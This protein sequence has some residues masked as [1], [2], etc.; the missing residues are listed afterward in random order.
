MGEIS[1]EK[2]NAAT[3][4]NYLEDDVDM[5][6]WHD[7]PSSPFEPHV[8]DQENVAP[9][10][11][12]TPSKPIAG[13]EDEPQSA[14]RIAP[15]KK[16]GLQDRTSP[17]KM[18]PK[19]Q[20]LSAFDEDSFGSSTSRTSPKKASP[21]KQTPTKTSR[22][23]SPDSFRQTSAL[24]PEDE[25]DTEPTPLSK[26]SSSPHQENILRENE[27]LTVAMRLMDQTQAD[28]RE[29]ASAQQTRSVEINIGDATFD[30]TEFNPDGPEFTS[31]DDTSF[32]M[33][34][35]MPGIDM[36]KFAALRQSPT[37][38]GLID[39]VSARSAHA[40]GASKLT[41]DHRQRPALALR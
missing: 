33:F 29:R 6:S 25:F 4:S 5:T 16:V 7:P 34:S 19:K 23:V 24:H 32:S 10:A 17:L 28:N 14:I 38:N 40:C 18:S 1:P 35:E 8:H 15:E 26:R 13:F 9:N 39:P 22:N 2:L 3:N 41:V 21:M 37:K 11:A 27:G 20:L 31:M 12:M 36:T 30:D